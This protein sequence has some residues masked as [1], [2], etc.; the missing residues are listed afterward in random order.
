MGMREKHGR[1]GRPALT[2]NSRHWGSRII[3]ERPDGGGQ[4]VAE[5]LEDSCLALDDSYRTD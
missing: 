1:S 3:D 2:G 4:F 5:L